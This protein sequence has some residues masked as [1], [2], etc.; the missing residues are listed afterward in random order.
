MPN[1]HAGTNLITITMTMATA[2]VMASIS[3]SFCQLLIELP[4]LRIITACGKV[5]RDRS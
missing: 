3:T 5:S 1:V 2:Q 4:P